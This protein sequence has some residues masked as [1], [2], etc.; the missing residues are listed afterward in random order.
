MAGDRLSC[1]TFLANQFRLL[2]HAAAFI[3]VQSLQTALQEVAPELDLA[4]AQAVTV[5]VKLLRWRRG[6]GKPAGPFACTSV[7][8]IRGKKCGTPWR[9]GSRPD[10]PPPLGKKKG[11]PGAVGLA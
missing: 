5:R 1:S 8:P 10:F 3:L 9:S 6:C 2:L 11:H 4:R 7:R